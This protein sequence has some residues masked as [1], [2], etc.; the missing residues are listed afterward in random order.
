MRQLARPSLAIAIAGVGCYVSATVTG[1][2]PRFDASSPAPPPV[3]AGADGE[4]CSP[5]ADPSAPATFTTL[6]TNYFGPSPTAK[7]SC[8]F[9][10]N[11]CHASTLEPGGNATNYAC[12][13]MSKDEC[14]A[15]L[16]SAAAQNESNV[17]LV[18]AGNVD[19]SYLPRV[20]RQVDEP[21]VPGLL[22]MPLS[23]NSVAMCPSDIDRV[24][25][26]IANGAKND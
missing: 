7:A 10:K 4:G 2:D 24:K 14:Y 3:E 22:R 6:Y 5:L 13:P 11:G 26:W 1:G 9:V 15:S 23:P 12:S 18:V 19:A 21:L 17:P 20:L 8:S 16:T 25:A